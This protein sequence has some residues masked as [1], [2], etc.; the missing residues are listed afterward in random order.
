M[1]QLDEAVDHAVDDTLLAAGQLQGD[2]GRGTQQ[3]VGRNVGLLGNQIEGERERVRDTLLPR[4]PLQ[5]Q[6]VG[7]EHGF[8]FERAIGLGVVRHRSLELEGMPVGKRRSLRAQDPL[9]QG[10]STQNCSRD[11]R[12]PFIIGA[13]SEGGNEPRRHT[14]DLGSSL[15]LAG[16]KRPKPRRV[17]QRFE[18]GLQYD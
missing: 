1:A 17:C 18:W 10:P 11:S 16:R 12:W 14:R 2:D 6:D 9:G 7:S 8:H 4:E 3:I 13:T 5:K 15:D